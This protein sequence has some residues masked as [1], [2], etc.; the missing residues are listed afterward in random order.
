LESKN[1]ERPPKALLAPIA[2]V[3]ALCALAPGF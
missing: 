2:Q 1:K 3:S